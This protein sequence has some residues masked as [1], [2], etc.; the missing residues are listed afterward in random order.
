[1]PFC[2]SENRGLHKICNPFLRGHI[3]LYIPIFVPKKRNNTE[4]INYKSIAI[5]FTII[6][7]MVKITVITTRPGRK[8]THYLLY[9]VW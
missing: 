6:K 3:F 4:G 7:M 8:A 5:L 2:A 1:M 9:T